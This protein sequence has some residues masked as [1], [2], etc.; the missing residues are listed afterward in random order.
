MCPE[1]A[2]L[3]T[4]LEKMAAHDRAGA[5]EYRT[6]HCEILED[7]LDAKVTLVEMYGYG[8]FTFVIVRF[9]FLSHK[10]PPRH[11]VAFLRPRFKGPG[12]SL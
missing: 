12:T 7:P 9:D 8:A 11:A 3:K 1:A 10:K 5:A 2:H 6:A 4:I